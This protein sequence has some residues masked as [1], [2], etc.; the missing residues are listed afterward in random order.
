M[1]KALAM[2]ETREPTTAEECKELLARLDRESATAEADHEL[3]ERLLL[4]RWQG[5]EFI[6]SKGAQAYHREVNDETFY[7]LVEL[8]AHFIATQAF[9]EGAR[10]Y[11]AQHN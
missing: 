3:T 11:R 7:A 10:A 8:M 1:P 4:E 5:V 6:T 2:D 9:L